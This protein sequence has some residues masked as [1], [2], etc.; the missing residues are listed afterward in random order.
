MSLEVVLPIDI[1]GII[2]KYCSINDIVSLLFT[3]HQQ[4][5]IISSELIKNLATIY[6]YPYTKSL[7]KLMRYK[8]YT[9]E[10][11]CNVS[12]ITDDVRVFKNNYHLCNFNE[13]IPFKYGSIDVINYLLTKID[14]HFYCIEDA[15][16]H[17][18][19]Y[20][21]KTLSKRNLLPR[22][23]YGCI[24]NVL[25]AKIIFKYSPIKNTEELKNALSHFIS[26]GY[27][28]I[29]IILINHIDNVKFDCPIDDLIKSYYHKD[30]EYLSN[31][32]D[33]MLNKG[34]YIKEDDINTL[35]NANKHS[36][37]RRILLNSHSYKGNNVPLPYIIIEKYIS[38]KC[39][40][41]VSFSIIEMILNKGIQFDVEYARK[42]VIE[43]KESILLKILSNPACHI[44]NI[45]HLLR[46]VINRSLN[47]VLYQLLL[48]KHIDYDTVIKKVIQFKNTG[49]LQY[50]Q[51]IKDS[52]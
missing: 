36:L 11:L 27:W 6:H 8:N 43:N 21:I 32:I 29:L 7:K 19:Y 2:A 35:V 18:H 41:E 28:D 47:D 48:H 12:S 17:N 16:T 51:C 10:M 50:L 4:S 20:L 38:S 52:I 24:D 40:N 15:I 33:L 34:A 22:Y 1:I 45:E 14:I 39:E 49:C 26:K 25:M 31:I 44:D 3:S 5:N 9:P 30:D 42:L 23:I 46:P 13:R 37:I